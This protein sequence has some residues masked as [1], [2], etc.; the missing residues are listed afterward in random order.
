[1][2]GLRLI[3]NRYARAGMAAIFAISSIGV[4]EAQATT[5]PQ[6]YSQD[7]YAAQ[8]YR[9]ENPDRTAC[10][11]TSIQIM[12]NYIR[13]SGAEIPWGVDT[14]FSKQEE[15]LKW[16]R[17]HDAYPDGKIGSDMV[18]WRDGLEHFGGVPYAIMTFDSFNAAAKQ[19]VKSIA[20]Y[21]M[22]VGILGWAGR[23]AQIITGYD[24]VGNDPRKSD[25]FVIKDFRVTD[26]L[27]ADRMIH[28]KVKYGTLRGGPRRIRY[29]RDTDTYSTLIDPVTGD[30]P[31]D[32]NWIGKFVMVVPVDNNIPEPTPTPRPTATPTHEPTPT[33]TL[34][35]TPTPT[36]TLSP[37][38]RPTE[39]PTPT[40][41]PAFT[42]TGVEQVLYVAA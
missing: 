9:T 41:T 19:I 28:E 15:I 32:K 4:V 17:N 20:E 27:E 33:P 42:P 21:N 23:H 29:K 24:V 39:T 34:Q 2:E 40:D 18:G 7:T 3:D 5:T 8:G 1:M 38:P 16:I 26:P 13:K 22:P 11:A 25:N 30:N 6:L 10:V 35:P 36:L 14:S 12:L 37:T 31:A